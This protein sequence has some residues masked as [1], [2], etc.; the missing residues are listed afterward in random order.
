MCI[1]MILNEARR[2]YSHRS[3]T[4]FN[5]LYRVTAENIALKYTKNEFFYQNLFKEKAEQLGLGKIVPHKDNPKHKPDAWIN[6]KDELI[7]VEC[8]LYDFDT[9]ALKQ[10]TR[11][12]NFYHTKHGIAVARNL[13]VTLPD[14][15]EFI[16]FSEFTDD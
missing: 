13:T 2:L 4:I 5:D 10:L 11:Y 8:K 1:W 15:I 7:P 12:M 3:D 9:K 16:P 6:R 14:N